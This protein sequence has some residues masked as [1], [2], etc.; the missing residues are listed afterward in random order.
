[1]NCLL[2]SSYV[3]NQLPSR[4]LLRFR[5][6]IRF[7]FPDVRMYA[8]LGVILAFSW[9]KYVCV[10][11]LPHVTQM[12]PSVHLRGTVRLTQVYMCSHNFR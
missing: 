10:R 1:M 11:V 7:V 9:Y 4:K 5:V 6:P 12:R 3:F 8:F 2:A